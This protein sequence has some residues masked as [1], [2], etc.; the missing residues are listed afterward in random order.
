MGL[1]LLRHTKPLVAEGTCYGSTDL[2]V[3]ASFDEEAEAVLSQLPPIERIVSS[4]LRRCRQLAE[5][6]GTDLGLDIEVDKR[7][8]E[9]DFGRWEGQLWSDIDRLELDAWAED[10]YYARPHGGESVAM[11]AK[12][13]K[14]AL[15]TILE[16]RMTTLVVSHSGVIKS[17][18][19]EGRSPSDF[20]TNIDFGGLVHWVPSNKA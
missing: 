7:L 12:R 9:M 10:F 14:V 11:L 5:F 20:A 4:P 2:D 16:P 1:I 18:F 3:A 6:I 19:A 17:A 13:A 8:Q 15:H